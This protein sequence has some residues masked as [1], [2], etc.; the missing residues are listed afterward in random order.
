MIKTLKSKQPHQQKSTTSGKKPDS[1][2]KHKTAGT[3]WHH[4][5]V[6]AVIYNNKQRGT[7]LQCRNGCWECCDDF[8]CAWGWD[9]R[10]TM[11]RVSTTN[12]A[13]FWMSV[14][15]SSTR[16]A[17]QPSVRWT[18]GWTTPLQFCRENAASQRGLQ[19]NSSNG[20]KI[21]R[22][23]LRLGKFEAGFI[24]SR[25]LLISCDNL[26]VIVNNHR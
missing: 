22:L 2:S 21:V 8:C 15:V 6:S 24:L 20:Q 14:C 25:I 19:Q 12:H 26:S 23:K 16:R 5:L 17:S 4:T 3:I 13:S 9:E 18:A 1:S 7:H 11:M 10:W